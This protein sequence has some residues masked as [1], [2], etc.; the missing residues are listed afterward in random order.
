MKLYGFWRST[1][2]Y[3]VRAALNLKDVP[4]ETV[5]VDLGAGAQR[6]NDY[7]GLNPGAGVPT[8]VLTDGTVLTQSMAILDYL[9]AVYPNP[10]LLPDNPIL[11]AK[12]LAVAL[13]VALD[14]H[15]VNNLRVVGQLTSRFGGSAE[16]TQDWMIHWMEQGFAALEA[17]LAEDTPFALGDAPNLAD[18]CITAQV[19]NAHR[20][21][22][23][24]T[25]FPKTAQV[26]AACLAIPAIAAA[27]PDRQQDAKGAS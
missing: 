7:V 8:L 9:D 6:A 5:P 19:Y 21:G 10:R 24:L 22:V 4:Y 23:D 27:H 18:L 26:E 15:P 16:Q 14:I 1:T 2:T 11:R 12:V 25:K 13:T 17:M 20:W 3:R